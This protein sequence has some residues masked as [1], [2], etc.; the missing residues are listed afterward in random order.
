MHDMGEGGGFVLRFPVTS[1]PG[2]GL[3]RTH[4]YGFCGAQGCTISILLY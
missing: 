2:P 3:G 4:S 1:K